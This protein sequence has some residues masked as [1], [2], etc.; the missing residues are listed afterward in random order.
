MTEAY[1]SSMVT[2]IPVMLLIGAVEGAG[3]I[4]RWKD[5]PGK[6]KD[7]EV[8]ALPLY[9]GVAFSHVVVE[10]VLMVWL[11]TPHVRPKSPFLALSTASVAGVG[12]LSLI[13]AMVSPAVDLWEV[14]RAR[15]AGLRGES[16]TAG[17]GAP[18][19]TEA[20]DSA[21]G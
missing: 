14:L 15:R 9:L 19:A 1:A 2:V 12:F 13:A 17:T 10:I 11:A 18:E 5:D 16:R 20:P 4:R 8:A 21:D 6:I 7:W 3:L